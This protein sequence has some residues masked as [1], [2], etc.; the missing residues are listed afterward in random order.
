MKSMDAE[1][2]HMLTQN[3]HWMV[4]GVSIA[5][6]QLNIL[7]ISQFKVSESRFTEK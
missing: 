4:R 6:L 5:E 7:D 3:F 2:M 1:N